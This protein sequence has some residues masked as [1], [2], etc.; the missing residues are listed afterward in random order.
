MATD[1]WPHIEY[2]VKK[3]N[4]FVLAP[5]DLEAEELDAR[6]YA[7]F[8]AMGGGICV[9][10]IGIKFPARGLPD[11]LSPELYKRQ[12]GEADFH[13]KSWLTTEELKECVDY[14]REKLVAESNYTVE[15]VDES[16]EP[17]LKIYRYMKNYE[18]EEEPARLVFWFDN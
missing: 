15:D 9:D 3:K 18:D 4:A 14:V 8:C 13:T 5:I 11:D 6:N 2:F 10:G 12:K 16:L 7:M 1:I 17:Y